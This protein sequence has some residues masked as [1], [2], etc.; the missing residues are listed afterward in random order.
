M[1]HQKDEDVPE[2]MEIWKTNSRP[3]IPNPLKLNGDKSEL[4]SYQLSQ[5]NLSL[6]Q[7]TTANIQNKMVRLPSDVTLQWKFWTLA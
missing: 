2:T 4:L 6:I 7:Q 5:Y 3:K 1:T